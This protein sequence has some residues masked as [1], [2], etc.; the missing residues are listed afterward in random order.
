MERDGNDERCK[1]IEKEAEKV[2]ESEIEEEKVE[3]ETDIYEEV[4]L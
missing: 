1:Q 2:V 3:L 4:V